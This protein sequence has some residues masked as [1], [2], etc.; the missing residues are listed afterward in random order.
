MHFATTSSKC[1]VKMLEI[2]FKECGK[3]DSKVYVNISDG[4][5]NI[6]AKE[7]GPAKGGGG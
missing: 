4:L 3:Y 1:G 5:Y 7:G 2:I 6:V